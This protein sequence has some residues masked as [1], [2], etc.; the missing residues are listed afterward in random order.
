MTILETKRLYL[1]P[2]NVADA[3]DLYECAKDKRVGYPA[4]WPA[5]TSVNHSRQVIVDYFSED[6]VFAIVLKQT[7]KI[8]GCIALKSPA[9]S[10]FCANDKQA[11]IGY[12]LSVPYWGQGLMP[13]AAKCLL[14]YGFEVLQLEKV[15]CGYYD[16]NLQ[17]YKVAKKCG[18]VYEYTLQKAAVPALG[19]F[20]TEHVLGLDRAA[21]LAQNA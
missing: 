18:F 8:I 1:R 2:W 20:R 21:W 6:N 5:H 11:E 16:G 14:Q 4:G 12:W 9:Q 3:A 10:R 15:W 19:E 13:E 7:E 17:S